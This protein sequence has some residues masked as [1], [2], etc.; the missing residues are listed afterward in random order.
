[1][2]NLPDDDG[3]WLAG[4]ELDDDSDAGN[5]DLGTPSPLEEDSTREPSLD[6]STRTVRRRH[7]TYWHH[8]ERRRVSSAT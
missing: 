8:P 2:I 1:M 7:S 6:G 5:D 3:D 4:G